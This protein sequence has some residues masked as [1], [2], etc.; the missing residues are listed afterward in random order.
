MLTKFASAFASAL[1]LTV[2][3]LGAQAANAQ[4][5]LPS[6]GASSSST[7][8]SDDTPDRLVPIPLRAKRAE[9]TFDGSLDVLVDG[10][11]GRLAPGA[12]I[13]GA[14]N[15]LKLSGSLVGKAKCKYL[16]EDGTG[17][18]MSVW[19]LTP[20]EIATPDPK[21]LPPDVSPNK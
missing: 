6:T 12:R 9:I 21:P 16:Q 19:I 18:L 7:S 14:D 10:K 15:L 2:L 11:K 3:L 4:R 20:R 13:F 5:I 8:S 17:L 1:C